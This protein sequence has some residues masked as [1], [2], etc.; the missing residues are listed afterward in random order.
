LL[1]SRASTRSQIANGWLKTYSTAAVPT[2]KRRDGS[3]E[4]TYAG[5][6]NDTGP[7]RRIAV[8]RASWHA[9]HPGQ[10]WRFSIRIRGRISKDYIVVGIEWIGGSSA[11]YRYISEQD[12]YPLITTNWQRATVITPPLPKSVR[13][14]T[15]YIQIPEINPMS[16]ID[17]WFADPSLAL[18][19][20]S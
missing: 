9:P 3:I 12:V 13:T 5:S 18:S 10:R 16:R 7:H 1:E 17:V 4:V 2:Y 11:P 14:V 20:H 8:F 15:A 6:F 19:S